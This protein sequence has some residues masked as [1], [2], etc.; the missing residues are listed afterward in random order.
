V[1]RVKWFKWKC[2][3]FLQMLMDA[4]TWTFAL[5]KTMWRRC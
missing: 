5:P 2:N 3:S 1:H 4:W